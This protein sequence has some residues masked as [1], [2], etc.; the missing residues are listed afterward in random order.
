MS[1]LEPAPA[2]PTGISL[3]VDYPDRELHRWSSALRPIVALPGLLL[4]ALL[5]T[6]GGPTG[7]GTAVAGGGLLV[8]PTVAMLVVRRRYPRW[9]FDFNCELVRFA[10][11]VGAYLALMDD[12]YPSTEDEQ[13]VHVAIVYPDARRDL[14]R[15]LPLVKWLLV[16][17]HLLV[18]AVLW[19]GGVLA[20][21]WAWGHIVAGRRYPRG[22]FEYLVAVANWHLRVTA[23]AFLLVTD[24]YPPFRLHPERRTTLHA[25]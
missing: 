7:P 1:T 23:Y 15:W 5:G 16:L 14:N 20:V 24:T 17:P 4:L 18:L 3:R 19:L 2:R 9:W 25:V 13:A 12:R 8:V 6:G 11:R 22:A 21:L 10:A